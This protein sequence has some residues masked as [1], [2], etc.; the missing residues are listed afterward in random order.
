MFNYYSQEFKGKLTEEQF[1]AIVPWAQDTLK[2]VVDDNVPFWRIPDMDWNDERFFKAQCLQIDF[3]AESGGVESLKA[4]TPLLTEVE[5]AGFKY[6][7]AKRSAEAS[8]ISPLA[9]AELKRELML[10]G[11]TYL[12]LR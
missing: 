1:N 5:T 8:F 11:L 4:D 3:I 12:G 2:V 6:K 7:Y 9:K 10:A